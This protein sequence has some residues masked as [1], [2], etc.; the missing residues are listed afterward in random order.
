MTNILVVDDDS[1]VLRMVQVILE[2]G[3]YQVTLA[4]DARAGVNM[5]LSEKPDLMLVDIFMP[6]MDG[7]EA[8]RIIHRAQPGLPIVVMSGNLFRSSG[9]PT[10]DFLHMARMLGAVSSLAKPFRAGQLL[11]A[12]SRGLEN[13]V[14]RSA[15]CADSE[16][17]FG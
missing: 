16:T 15:A 6:E 1:S 2:S 5:V 17:R 13:A 10:P 14:Q 8:L 7:L 11:D 3:G 9:V 4:H 12:V